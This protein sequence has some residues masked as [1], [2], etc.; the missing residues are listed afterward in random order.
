MRD[1]LTEAPY[2]CWYL[3]Q[4][5]KPSKLG[6]SEHKHCADDADR[7]VDREKSA[8]IEQRIKIFSHSVG[9]PLAPDNDTGYVVADKAQEYH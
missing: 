1:A 4:I 5:Y 6:F 3:I 7:K 2:F 9:S 8:V